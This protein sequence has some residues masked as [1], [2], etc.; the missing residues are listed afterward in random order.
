[1]TSRGIEVHS[2]KNKS[3]IRRQSSS[4]K[5]VEVGLTSNIVKWKMIKVEKSSLTKDA[6]ETLNTKHFQ[7]VH[8]TKI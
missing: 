2:L 4:S 6:L 7:A 5:K 1:M 3:E 8:M